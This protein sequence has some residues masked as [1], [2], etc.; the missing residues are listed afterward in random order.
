MTRTEATPDGEEPDDDSPI[1]RIHRLA[2][3]DHFTTNIQLPLVGASA[4]LRAL[5]S[6]EESLADMQD[7]HAA[8]CEV[9]HGVAW[10]ENYEN[11]REGR[12]S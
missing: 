6:I 7:M 12:N 9:E 3:G 10:A 2:N 4:L 5:E 11:R 8:T 1:D